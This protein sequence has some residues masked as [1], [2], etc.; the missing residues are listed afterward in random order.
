MSD[1]SRP[2]SGQ[3]ERSQES[4]SRAL[5]R[6]NNEIRLFLEAGR[7]LGR[8]LDLDAIYDILYDIVAQIMPC[9]T[10][11]IS[12]YDREEEL[13]HCR[14]VR[15]QNRRQDVE[16]LPPIPL[17]PEGRGI[18]ARAI[19]S[20]EAFLI[21]DWHAEISRNRTAYYLDDDSNIVDEPPAG[22]G[23]TQMALIVPLQLE[24]EVTG[25]LQLLSDGKASY[26]ERDLHFLE[27]LAAQVAA[28]GSN[29]LLYRQA[30][31][32]IAERQLAEAAEREQRVLAEALADT[33]AILNRTLDLDEVLDLILQQVGRVAP[34]QGTNIMLIKD[35]V[36]R[37]RR[38]F[39]YDERYP[40]SNY[41]L[42]YGFNVMEA[43]TMRTMIRTRQAV[44]IDDAQNFEGWLRTPQP[45]WVRSYAGVPI[46]RDGEVIGFLNLDAGTPNFFTSAHA[47]RLQA[48]ADQVAVAL[49]NAQLYE[50]LAH[51]SDYLENAV[52]A[53]TVEL[54]RTVEQM[55]AIVNY[56]PQAI[57]LCN[58]N[59]AVERGN[60]AVQKLFAY[61][62]AELDSL[63]LHNLVA[64]EDRERFDAALAE[65]LAVRDSRRLQL[66]AQRKDGSVFDADVAL[67]TIVEQGQVS[68]LVCS[69]HDI[70]GLKEVE[71]MKDAFVSNVS[72]EL[73]TPISSLKLYH[74]LLQRDPPRREIYMQR[75]EREID[76]LNVI[77]EDL[78]R[79]SRLEQGRVTLQMQPGDLRQL[80]SQHVTD[81]GPLAEQHHL[82]L[83]FEDVS[84]PVP[85]MM[86]EGLMGQVFSILLTNAFT[87]T[88]PG[89]QIEVGFDYKQQD[90]RPYTAFYVR[91]DGPGITR[92]EQSELFKRFFRGLAGRRS[93]AGG[94][95]LGLSIAEEIVRQHGGE[96]ELKSNG[97]PGKGAMFSVWLPQIG[98]DY[99]PS[100]AQDSVARGAHRQYQEL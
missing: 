64:A 96:I 7:Q 47:G 4:T 62:A 24:G 35:G 88:P 93:G 63:A 75:M 28:A 59:G 77:I 70:S 45:S 58:L 89:G 69:I 21:D 54:Q 23:F 72:H 56:S 41:L 2:D 30:Q 86:D 27:T 1:I 68:S 17:E 52:H 73:R 20:R 16:H 53:R 100:P 40:I 90:G 84:R 38:Y 26:S 8:T 95:G 82:A 10:L 74:G 71:R 15:H 61:D 98:P 13:I 32:E 6:R 36:A 81:R 31:Q 42:N 48:F 9:T 97:I 79:L 3:D 87:Y 83:S 25:V 39:G 18:Q 99:R 91:D 12:H 65:A 5:Q 51:H 29:A 66:T 33:A 50:T 85:V 76:R 57:V 55:N 49:H 11:I 14:Y 19:R 44:L 67:A 78:L 94:T 22:E 46:V 60:P 43:R 37:V 80:V 34:H 92:E